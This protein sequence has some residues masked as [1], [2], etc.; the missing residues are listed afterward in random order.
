MVCFVDRVGED[1]ARG[2]S[3]VCT[4]ECDAD[5]ADDEHLVEPLKIAIVW[6]GAAGAEGVARLLERGGDVREF[7]HG[8]KWGGER[9]GGHPV[10]ILISDLAYYVE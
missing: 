8:S 3:G 4:G 1:Y 5:A 7:R 2:T 9:G 6:I 10:V